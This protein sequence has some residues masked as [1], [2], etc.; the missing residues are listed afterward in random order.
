M[1]DSKRSGPPESTKWKPG[2]PSP[3]PAGRPRTVLRGVPPADLRDEV[4][5]FSSE[6]DNRQRKTR[7]RQWLEM[8]DRRARQGSPRHLELLLAYGWGRPKESLDI[9]QL[10]MTPEQ[11][12]EVINSY[13]ARLTESTDGDTQTVTGESDNGDK[14]QIQ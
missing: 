8:A 14:Q 1:G 7:L 5:G 6:N 9:T 11:A 13:M 12:D 3:N 10:P 4:R 2:C